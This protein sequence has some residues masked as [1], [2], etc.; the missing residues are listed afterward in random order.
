MY[1]LYLRAS[2][3][4]KATCIAIDSD[5]NVEDS[6][7]ACLL[8]NQIIGALLTKIKQNT[9]V[10]MTRNDIQH[11]LHQQNMLSTLVSHEVQACYP[12]SPLLRKGS[13]PS[14]HTP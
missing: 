13:I 3:K 10:G 11:D 12:E 8:E 9:T 2:I 4:L 1:S 14:N 7:V 6:T 5:P